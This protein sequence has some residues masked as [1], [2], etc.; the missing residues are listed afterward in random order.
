MIII[1]GDWFYL[2]PTRAWFKNGRMRF[3]IRFE[4]ELFF[5]FDGNLYSWWFFSAGVERRRQFR[6]LLSAVQWSCRE[7][8]RRWA[9]VIP[10]LNCRG[11]PLSERKFYEKCLVSQWQKSGQSLFF[12]KK[13]RALFKNIFLKEWREI[14]GYE[15]KNKS[16]E[17]YGFWSTGSS[18]DSKNWQ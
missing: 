7:I 13:F 18:Y 8:S 9:W 16:P 17:S 2:L 14:N 5:T 11:K 1:V 4:S 3:M 15:G 6:A 12:Q 10:S